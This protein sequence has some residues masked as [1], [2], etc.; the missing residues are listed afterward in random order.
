MKIWSTLKFIADHPLNKGRKIKA[1]AGFV[2]WQ[3]G[4]RLVP[5]DVVYPWINGIKFFVHPGETGLTQNIYCGLQEFH[6][7]AYVL[8]VMEAGDTFVDVGANAG[9]YMLLACGVKGA[10]GYC[11][12]PVP[13]TY[14]RLTNNIKLNDLSARVKAFNV[15]V[16][17]KEGELFFTTGL[18]TTNHAVARGEADDNVIRVKV[19]PLDMVLE[20]VNPALIKIDVEGLEMLVLN[21]MRQTLKKASLHSVIMELNGNGKR[22]GFDDKDI[23]NSMSDYS[24]R[25]YQY[26]PFHR[27]LIPA[28]E[29]NSFTG[30]TLFLRN[31]SFI[32][33]R[34]A[35]AGRVRI[36]YMEI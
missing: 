32:Q 10:G 36:G 25:M 19:L 17:D 3:I 12:E 24:F 2:K 21:G 26:D 20:E 7:M 30:N 27:I 1:L 13:S 16:A 4:S 11:F 9:S 29:S 18:D 6:D 31:V 33:D 14:Q 34:L 15:G 28:S 23:M 8:H 22:Y 5:G 35:R